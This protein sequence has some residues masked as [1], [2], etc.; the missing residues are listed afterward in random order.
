[1]GVYKEKE[2]Y[3]NKY[4]EELEKAGLFFAFGQDQFEKYRTYRDETL[5]TNNYISVGMGGYIHKNDKEKLDKFFQEI[6]PKLKAEFLSKV[7]REDLILYELD[8]HE[9]FYTGDIEDTYLGLK[10]YYDDL[11]E[12][13]VC[14]V[15]RKNAKY[16]NAK[17][18]KGF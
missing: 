5:D 17:Y 13:E 4:N 14:E 3:T 10:Y 15:Y 1:M 7:K 9:C 18:R 6:A 2:N 16:W 11:T 12:E 8:N